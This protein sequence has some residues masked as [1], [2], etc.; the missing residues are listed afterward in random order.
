[1]HR[2][3]GLTQQ[4]SVGRISS[5]FL[6]QRNQI[7][8]VEQHLHRQGLLTQQL[9][10]E[11]ITPPWSLV[12][13]QQQQHLIHLPNRGSGTA[14]QP[15]PQEVM[16]LMNPRR[17]DQDQL[18]VIGGED[19]AQPIAGGL[20]H[21]RGD[22]NLVANEL[23]HQR[24]LPHIGAADQSNKPRAKSLRRITRK[25]TRKRLNHPL[26]VRCHRLS[27]EL[28]FPPYGVAR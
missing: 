6:L 10:D 22:R 5:I 15:L 20:G 4:L 17:I 9:H 11:G 8:L 2:P 12:S 23:I 16:G 3:I 19:R 25:R 21:R 7:P 1:M 27:P 26:S 18:S 28:W 13:L 24:G 14:N